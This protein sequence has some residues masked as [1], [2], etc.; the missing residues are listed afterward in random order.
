MAPSVSWFHWHSI[1]TSWAERATAPVLVLSPF[2]SDRSYTLPTSQ[3]YCEVKGDSADIKCF[4]NLNVQYTLEVLLFLFLLINKIKPKKEFAPSS[5]WVIFCLSP[6]WKHFHLGF[7]D[8]GESQESMILE[9]K[10]SD[11]VNETDNLRSRRGP[12]EL[13]EDCL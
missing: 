10:Q 5:L 13:R 1:I 12:P 2:G 8:G 3:N 9:R 6:S 11:G 4:I 7:A